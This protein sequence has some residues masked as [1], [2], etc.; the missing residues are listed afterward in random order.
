MIAARARDEALRPF[1]PGIDSDAVNDSHRVSMAARMESSDACVAVPVEAVLAGCS[2]AMR[3]S[4]SG[5]CPLSF[6]SFRS[7]IRTN[8]WNSVGGTKRNAL[9]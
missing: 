7:F 4:S 3:V 9:A 2:D 1:L 8:I 5:T 6:L